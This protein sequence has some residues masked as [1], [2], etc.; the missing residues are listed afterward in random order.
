ML[1][2]PTPF[3]IVLG[4]RA[5]VLVGCDGLIGTCRDKF[6]NVVNFGGDPYAPSA[7]QLVEPAP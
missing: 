4:D 5:I 1:L 6:N 3:D 7:Q 2:T